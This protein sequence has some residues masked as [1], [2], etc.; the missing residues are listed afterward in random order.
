MATHDKPAF[1]NLT[2]FLVTQAR[3]LVEEDELVGL[4]IS[5]NLAMKE[6]VLVQLWGAESNFHASLVQRDLVEVTNGD[7]EKEEEDSLPLTEEEKR[8]HEKMLAEGRREKLKVM[9]DNQRVEVNKY[10][11]NAF[12]PTV[13]PRWVE[14]Q[15][16]GVQDKLWDLL[17]FNYV[18]PIHAD[19]YRFL[20]SLSDDEMKKCNEKALTENTDLCS[21]DYPLTADNMKLPVV[22]EFDPSK[23]VVTN[24]ALSIRGFMGPRVQTA[25]AELKWIWNVGRPYVKCRCIELQKGDCGKNITWFDHIFWYLLSDLHYLFSEAPS[26]RARIR[27]F[28]VMARSAWRA[29]VLTSVVFFHI[30]EIMVKMAHNVAIDPSRT[31]QTI[32]DDPAVLLQKFPKTMAKLILPTRYIRPSERKR[33]DTPSSG[34]MNKRSRKGCQTTLEFYIEPPADQAPGAVTSTPPLSTVTTQED[35]QGSASSRS[36]RK[37]PR[38]KVSPKVVLFRA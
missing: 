4:S 29:P 21:G 10:A 32:L 38:G 17:T 19:S 25:M 7:S 6:K 31:P 24:S 14:S 12:L 28:R 18:A 34:P 36:T 20:A 11:R 35:G 23:C 3:N 2:N 15:S 9:A 13:P 30:R 26:L 33:R 1:L 37:R 16:R 22:G 5:N 8:F 27:A